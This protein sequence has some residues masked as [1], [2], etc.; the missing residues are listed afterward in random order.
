MAAMRM[1]I[2]REETEHLEVLV[3][4]ARFH[5]ERMRDRSKDICE[6][7]GAESCDFIDDVVRRDQ[8]LAWMLER[9]GIEVSE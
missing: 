5:H 7:L 4:V 3:R 9:L 2:T 1:T 6:M 8:P